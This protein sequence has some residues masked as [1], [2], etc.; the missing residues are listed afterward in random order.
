MV[1]IRLETQFELDRTKDNGA[2]KNMGGMSI[3]PVGYNKQVGTAN[4]LAVEYSPERS[5]KGTRA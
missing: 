4:M 3:R 2:D 1:A 5:A